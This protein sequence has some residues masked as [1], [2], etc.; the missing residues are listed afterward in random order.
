MSALRKDVSEPRDGLRT[1]SFHQPIPVPSYLLALVV[2]DL[3][4]KQVGPR[5]H[6]WSE[7]QLVDKAAFEFSEVIIPVQSGSEI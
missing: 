5:S 2:G 1:H 7:P 4:S 3:A 6:V